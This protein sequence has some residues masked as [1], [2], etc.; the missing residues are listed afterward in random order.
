MLV[1]IG[2]SVGIGYSLAK[3]SFW[4]KKNVNQDEVVA[5]KPL[6]RFALVSDSEGEN[7]LLEKALAQAEGAGI[8]FV[9]GLGDWTNVGT[10][11]TLTSAKKVFDNSKLEY[12]M[13]A[14]D[15]DLWDSRNE[16][17]APPFNFNQVFG[18]ASRLIERNGI[19][20]VL[21][22]NSDIY[23]G[24]DSGSWSLVTG[25]LSKPAKLH[26]V[27]VHKTPFHPESRHVMGSENAQ[28]AD[29]AN[30]FM[31]LLEE[32]KVDGF[33]SG[34]LHF[35]AQFKSPSEAVKITTVGAVASEKNFQGPR[36]AI[37]TVWEDYSWEVEDVEIR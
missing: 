19:Q 7:E 13:T 9:I 18:D 31:Q 1:L 11:E 2:L 14:G 29:Q 20:I 16:G 26:F 15:H 27:M 6:L 24:I 28:V 35:F 30:Q 21:L 3:D 23:K 32:R 37:V 33:F 5:K 8:N 4:Q 12:F 34:D 36:F 17:K 22:D 25:S 10:M